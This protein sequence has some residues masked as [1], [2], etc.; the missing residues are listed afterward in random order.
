MGHTLFGVD[1]ILHPEKQRGK[2]LHEQGK[3]IEINGRNSGASF[4]KIGQH[5]YYRKFMR[6]ID[7]AT[8]GKKTLFHISPFWLYKIPD[9]NNRNRKRQLKEQAEYCESAAEH[10]L[11]HRP[12]IAT[13]QHLH[14]K[15]VYEAQS[16]DRTYFPQAALYM[17]AALQEKIDVE[18]YESLAIALNKIKKIRSWGLEQLKVEDLLKIRKGKHLGKRKWNTGVPIEMYHQYEDLTDIGLVWG[19]LN[20]HFESKLEGKVFNENGLEHVVSNKALFHFMSSLKRPK[21]GKLEKFLPRT[22]MY[23][24]GLH[25][26]A[27]FNRWVRD[28]D[29]R[30]FV[31]KPLDECHGIG[32]QFLTRKQLEKY[33]SHIFNTPKENYS[34]VLETLSL[35]FVAGLYDSNQSILVQETVPSMKLEENGE[36]FTAC[37]RAIVLNGSYMGSIWRTNKNSRGSLT[38]RYRHNITNGAQ[39]MAVG[40]KEE[41]IIK[42]IAEASVSA[43]LE[44]Y[45]DAQDGL[46]EEDTPQH[47]LDA[48]LFGP[49]NVYSNLIEK[50]IYWNK[51]KKTA[52][53]HGVNLEDMFEEDEDQLLDFSEGKIKFTVNTKDSGKYLVKS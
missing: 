12:L 2:A 42:D 24:N 48:A 47:L 21:R 10:D 30:V 19:S 49:G 20:R 40:S 38:D 27:G 28:S 13:S 5:E 26:R 11:K 15:A 41:T 17:F 14:E 4:Y 43:L 9:P 52:E 8:G 6:E 36:K 16:L 32:V 29:S 18:G 51:I 46:L 53:H 34:W 37:A 44:D 39:V 31:I 50:S 35:D 45:Q 33:D 22:T 1:I 7:R 23:G 25:T 3:V